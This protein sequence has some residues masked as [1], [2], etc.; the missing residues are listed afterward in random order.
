MKRVRILFCWGQIILGVA[1]AALILFLSSN[2]ADDLRN[3]LDQADSLLTSADKQ[4]DVGI[5][6]LTKLNSTVSDIGGTFGV[7]QETITS[8]M[9][10]AAALSGTAAMW[11]DQSE[12]FSSIA[13][14]ASH[15]MD[16][17]QKELPIRVPIVEVGVKPW[18]FDVPTGLDIRS[19]K[20]GFNYPASAEVKVREEGINYPKGASIQT[21][22]AS[23]VRGTVKFDYPCGIDIDMDK[24]EFNVPHSIDIRTSKFEFD[25]PR[26]H[27]PTFDRIEFD[28][29]DTV[30]VEYRDLMKDEKALLVET[31]AQL[32]ST[33]DAI[34]ET[35]QSLVEISDLLAMEG[36]VATALKAVSSELTKSQAT[37]KDITTDEIPTFV[38]ELKKQK[39]ALAKT[40]SS[41]SGLQGAIVPITWAL[42]IFPLAMVLNGVGLL[43]LARE[44]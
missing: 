25:L 36:D 13:L 17:F 35:S 34:S 11:G 3:G 15:I 39:E 31:S 33:A 24:F 27:A 41:L 10:S 12:K 23:F 6:V 8:A 21:C 32:I 37:I 4:L 38:D 9:K 22:K 28:V 1:L 20:T 42:M 2:Y 5:K 43:S 29:P 14:D 30:S 19:D 44:H 16:T 7:Y 26:I 18:S 40:H